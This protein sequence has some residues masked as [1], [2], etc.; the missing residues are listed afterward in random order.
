MTMRKFIGILAALIVGSF[1]VVG[2]VGTSQ[3]FPGEQG[4][5]PQSLQKLM[6]NYVIQVK[7]KK[8]TKIF[9]C[10]YYA[11]ATACSQPPCCKKGHW[12]KV[13]DEKPL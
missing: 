11:P 4:K 1:F 6:D 9:E 13:C 3:A 2:L 7:K 10:E 5:L 8:C 12:Y